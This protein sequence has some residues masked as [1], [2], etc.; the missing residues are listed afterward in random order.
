M[1]RGNS[2]SEYRNVTVIINPTQ[3]GESNVIGEA[4]PLDAYKAVIGR[5]E[6]M[7]HMYA[8]DNTISDVT[9]GSTLVTGTV[10][11][12]IYV[13]DLTTDLANGTYTFDFT[14]VKPN[15]EAKNSEG[16]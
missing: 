11:H 7:E 5:V 8:K 14:E 10:A 12:Q 16:Q 4:M 13:F 2:L 3:D 9:A 1:P 6:K 15:A